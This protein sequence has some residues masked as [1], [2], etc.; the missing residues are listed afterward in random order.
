MSLIYRAVWTDRFTD[1]V[2]LL[3]NEFA[4]WIASRGI[5]PTVIPARGVWEADQR[6]IE[7]RR[8]DGEVGAIC[9]A[10]LTE[11]DAQQRTWSTT[12]TATQQQGVAGYWIDLDCSAPDGIDLAAP[13]LVR[14]LLGSGAEP[15][16]GGVQ[17]SAKPF[18]PPPERAAPMVA[19]LADPSRRI[20]VAV[21]SEDIRIAPDENMRRAS[22]AAETLAGIAA[23]WVLPQPTLDRFNAGMGEGFAV[24]G[25]AVRLYLPDL[26]SSNPDDAIRH[27]WFA[28]R[29]F[30]RHPRRAGQLLGRRLLRSAV[31]TRPPLSWE[32]LRFLIARPDDQELAAR[33]ETIRA[34]RLTLVHGDELEALRHHS[35]ELIDLLAIAEAERDEDR[36][37]TRS[38]IASLRQRITELEDEH[39][40]DVIQ[41]EDLT[42]NL[43][44]VRNSFRTLSSSPAID[45]APD[46]QQA[47][48]PAS[49]SEA[50][51]A[52][53]RH[54][55]F[56]SIPPSALREL[57]RLD[58]NE[59]RSVWAQHSWLA[60]QALNDYSEA[61]AN[62]A[63]TAGGFYQWCQA[64]GHW[65]TAKLSMT[66]SETVM[67]NE[68]LAACRR[69]PV[70]DAVD[71]SGSIVMQAHLKV[72]PGGG[73]TI[74]RIYFHDDTKGATGKVH[75]GFFG[76][77]ELMPNTRT[78]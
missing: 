77:H 31:D 36:R 50:A 34:D 71:A 40:D 55:P 56:L 26:D 3:D 2:A 4:S 63:F 58:E 43:T 41:L 73:P 51:D 19:I 33:V 61:V 72:Q 20:P 15:S 28:P 76:P 57:E 53:I 22:A 30:D 25:G 8:G 7:V 65:S 12:A 5:D 21:F 48:A 6:R 62:G 67:A 37:R 68:K 44:A 18:V 66:E 35:S 75:V 54:L 10:T 52:A 23:I 32:Q 24:W 64:T 38:E 78:N 13:R 16:A 45:T 17:L 59:K 47:E 49:P 74:P 70:D 46:Q 11:T 1:A 29:L 60:F 9:R 14:Q 39:L 69:L 42:S 27:R